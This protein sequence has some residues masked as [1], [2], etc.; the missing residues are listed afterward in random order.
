MRSLL[1]LLLIPFTVYSQINVKDQ[2]KRT[3][4]FSTFYAAYNGNNSISDVTTYSVLDGLNT[5]TTETP[6]DYSAVFGI[7][8]IQRFGYEPN[9]QNRFKNGTENS[10]SDAATV[11]SKSKG[12]EY[13][14]EFDYRRQQGKEFLN[15]DHFIRYIADRYVL[16]V[17][18]LEDGFADI[19]YFEA[20]QRFRHKFNRKFSVNIG[21]MQRISEPYGFDPFADCLRPD[22]SIPWM[23]IATDMGY[24]WGLNDIYTDPNGEI[25]A[26]STEVFQEVVVPQILSDY[27]DIQRNALPNKWEYSAVLGFD[28]YRYSKNFWLH[29]WA[30]LLPYHIDIE[31]QYSYHK[32]NDGQWLDYSGGLIFGY[33]FNRSLG[34]FAEGRYHQYWNRSWYE[35]STGINYIIL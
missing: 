5:T 9:I 33:R 1:L 32:F 14:F 23:K 30:N 25:V 35:F 13:L 29:S 20:S 28:Y 22:G 26:N 8:K 19:G 24:N 11:G 2:I 6:Y 3:L 12:F 31:N 21:G 34:I 7:R 10:F 18:Y 15:Q 17:E 16:K 4:K 27:A